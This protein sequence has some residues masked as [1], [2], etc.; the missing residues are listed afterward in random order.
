V[1]LVYGLP[2]LAALLVAF[3]FV[4]R[5]ARRQRDARL[6]RT[7]TPPKQ[8]VRSLSQR[9]EMRAGDP[10]SVMDDLQR[11]NS[12]RMSAPSEPRAIATPSRSRSGR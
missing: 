12:R 7:R 4:R 5:V 10:I 3:A 6:R 1:D 2:A 9:S 11:T 8:A